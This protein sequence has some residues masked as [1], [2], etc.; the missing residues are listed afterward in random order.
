MNPT[1]FR[2]IAVLGLA[3]G[4]FLGQSGSPGRIAAAQQAPEQAAQPVPPPVQ[5]TPAGNAVPLAR[6]GASTADHGLN[7]FLSRLVDAIRDGD[8]EVV[9][10]C[11]DTDQM[12]AEIQRQQ[13]A[14]TPTP[15]EKTAFRVAL[16]MVVGNGLFQEGVNGGWKNF[17]LRR[18]HVAAN[19]MVVDVHALDKDARPVGLVQL[20][21]S[22]DAKG[23]WSLYDWQ[24][25]SSI[26]RTSTMVAMTV[27]AFRQEPNASR[28]QR[29]IAA[30]AFASRGD[31][32][33]AERTVL[34]LVNT[35]LPEALEGPRWLLYAQ[36]KFSQDQ[37]DKSLECLEQAVKYDPNMI[38]L[39]KIKAL[40]YAELKNPARSLEFAN[41]ALAALG[42][43]AELYALAGNALAQ[44]GRVDEAAAAYRKGLDDDPNLV[45]NLTGLAAVLPAGKKAEVADRLAR[46]ADP[47]E[48]FPELAEALVASQDHLTL[49][50]LT[51]G[52]NKPT[53]DESVLDYYRARAASL[54][55][56]PAEAAK[57]LQSAIARADSDESKRFYT[58][59]LLDTQLQAGRSLDA[60]HD[61][62][63][64]EY[65]FTYLARQLSEAESADTLLALSQAH[66]KRVPACPDAYFY[67]GRALLMKEKYD[68]AAKAFAGGIALA[69]SA[70]QREAFRSNL[71]NALYKA[72]RGLAAYHDV[73][74]ESNTLEQLAGLYLG[75]QQAKP[76]IE[77][78][79]ERRKIDVNDARPDVWEAQARMILKDYAGAAKLLKTAIAGAGTAARKR[80]LVNTLLDAHLANKTPAQGYAEAPD[81]AHA[82]SYLAERLVKDEDAAGLTAV[83]DAHRAR[84]PKDSRL[85]YYAG[86]AHMLTSDYRAADQDFARGLEKATNRV[87][88]ARLLNNRL[89]ARC[90]LGEALQSY[91][92]ADD[93]PLIYRLLVPLLIEQNQAE[94]LTALVKAHRGIAPKEPTLGLWEAESKW[95][96]RDYN[97]V[98]N[99]LGRDREAILS[100]PA[101]APHYEDRLVRSLVRLKKYSDA[102]RAAKE[103][104]DRDGD[105][106]FEAVV[107]VAAGDVDRA[108]PLLEQ[109]AA[110]GY[111]LA[112]FD[113]DADVA[114]LLKTPAFSEL[115]QKL[116]TTN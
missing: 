88:S 61:S 39:P 98:V 15:V 48:A 64:P 109:C 26:F 38:A 20:W 100:D 106:W 37:P 30:A 25:A 55:G 63:E 14:A 74:P 50:R 99:A 21:L 44:L 32:A 87:A 89:R 97:G 29:L 110:R 67:E 84:A 17:R 46:C 4:L 114:P 56:Q 72:G 92:E 112:E 33:T 101:N 8:S 91:Q 116:S 9:S 65:A 45:S 75:D 13:I 60:Y 81:P 77:L 68:E 6:T 27:S 105:P 80:S 43:D 108:G 104:T 86:Q 85:D 102:A 96:A 54:K 78:A 95:L 5:D 79:A 62:A 2:T 51:N 22:R 111:T 73:G 11:V 69:K 1:S 47:A 52:T 18:Q 28:W 115:R 76:L 19:P 10:S 66:L 31:M 83:I 41:Q 71:V 57:L 23:A 107:A 59:Q 49:E 7:E 58:D 113:A 40:I 3:S 34:E 16:R 94:D 82:F 42:H 36:I 103:S 93:K 12:F 53:A 24:E 90:K 70:P 35:P